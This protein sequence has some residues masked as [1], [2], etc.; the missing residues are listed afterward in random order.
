M[1]ATVL[2]KMGMVLITVAQLPVIDPLGEVLYHM[3]D[4]EDIFTITLKKETRRPYLST[5]AI[6]LTTPA[7]VAL[8]QRSL[9]LLTVL[10]VNQNSLSDAEWI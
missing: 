6:E 5:S 2:A 3:A 10:V 1:L 8:G 4:E 9:E 7:R